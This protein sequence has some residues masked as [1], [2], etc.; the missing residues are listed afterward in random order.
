[1]GPSLRARTPAPRPG[2]GPRC[3]EGPAGDR[4][5]ARGPWL[6]NAVDRVSDQGPS[7]R[8][9]TLGLER[10]GGLVAGGTVP[11]R[12]PWANGKGGG[13]KTTGPSLHARTLA[14]LQ[15][16]RSE[17]LGTVPAREDPGCPFCRRSTR[18][19]DRPCARGPWPFPGNP[20]VD[21]VGPSLRARTL[22]RG[23]H[24]ACLHPGTV[25]AREDPGRGRTCGW[26]S[27]RDRP[28]ARGPWRWM[29][30]M[31]LEAAGPSLRAR[32]LESLPH[33][34]QVGNGTVPARED[35][36]GAGSGRGRRVGD[37]PCARGPWTC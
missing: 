23:T 29:R 13:G 5:C 34:L 31:A 16:R 28:C 6:I 18:R 19:G 12:G 33:P 24:C 25:P 10:R 7:L 37:R 8:A 1:M 15:S 27:G 36:G 14:G 9:R 2:R 20:G 11:A 4:P 3:A 32:T 21:D 35:P 17:E 30:D 22:G 26:G